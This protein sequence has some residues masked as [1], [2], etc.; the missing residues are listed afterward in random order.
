M[1]VLEADFSE[2][3]TDMS[4]VKSTVSALLETSK[5]VKQLEIKKG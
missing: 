1:D 5:D 3:K 2:L 4:E